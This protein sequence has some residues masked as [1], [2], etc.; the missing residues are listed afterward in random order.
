[1]GSRTSPA[2]RT[3][4]LAFL[5]A[6]GLLAVLVDPHPRSDRPGEVP[7]AD[8]RAEVARAEGDGG[9]AALKLFG[10]DA[11]DLF[12]T[13]RTAFRDLMALARLDAP[14]RAI[15]AGPW[16]EA[17]TQWARA[18]RLG[19]YLEHLGGLGPESWT[20]LR[21]VPGCLPLLG[22]GARQAEA[23]IA[24]HGARAWRL[25][26][27]LDFADDVEG[28]ERVAR[29]LALYG[30]GMLAVNESHG[31]AL[32]LLFVPPTGDGSGL[33]PRLFS[34][35]IHR[36]GVDDA[37]A[38]FLGNHDDLER[39]VLEER[40][41]PEDLIRAFDL[42]A[43]QPE[44]VRALA[45]D[46]NLVVRLLLERRGREP[47]GAE[48]L[49]RCGPEAAD[50]LF[51][52][53]GY[54]HRTEE[55]PAALAIL[56]RHGGPGVELLRAF[57][58]DDAWH[59]LLRRA[60]LMDADREPLI[61][62]LAGKLTPSARRQDQIGRYLEMPRAQIVAEDT[63]PTL[64]GQVLEWIPGYVAAHTAY[65][66]AR[67]YRIETS[68]AAWAVLDGVTTVALVGRLAA[69][70]I[71]TVGRPAVKAGAGAAIRSVE[72]QAAREL[73][74]NEGRRAGRTILTRLPGALASLTRSLPGLLPT[75]DVTAVAR[76]VAGVA[77]RVGVRTWGKLDRRIIMRGDRRVV[78][79]VFSREVGTQILEE[80][81]AKVGE[82]LRGAMVRA[83]PWKAAAEEVGELGACLLE[84]V[85]P[86]LRINAGEWPPERPRERAV[87][88]PPPGPPPGVTPGLGDHPILRGVGMVSIVA[89][90]ALAVPGVRRAVGRPFARK[91]T[92]P[93]T[94]PSG[95]RPRPYRE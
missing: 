50:L 28:V 68:E 86:K 75:L 83:I 7:R 61:V 38:L 79:D 8:L 3:T 81:R 6:A 65:D 67:G 95:P 30:D 51:E 78:V 48:I 47:I 1:M 76:S 57:R 9:L 53:G 42:L 59:R 32:A 18:G 63:P 15:S 27:I 90:L 20:L 93:S 69:Q 46:S 70:A 24:R 71:K 26:L 87:P 21:E 89:C 80:L 13:D 94:T 17:V 88:A 43:G 39:L 45:S 36:L 16:R 40:R 19:P 41:P 37:G 10:E 91:S 74:A 64:A 92:S 14:G 29:A 35:A 85:V 34:E 52:N 5:V 11:A 22:R 82:E 84:R 44:G 23:M 31:P 60:E 56:A 72:R 33:L 58:D 55:K 62:R 54:A 12:A 49:A 77:R 66:A 2:I 4:S 73:V 25:F